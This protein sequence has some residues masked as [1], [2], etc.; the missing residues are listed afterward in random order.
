MVAVAARED[1]DGAF[2]WVGN[3]LN[4]GAVIDTAHGT[5]HGRHY[6]SRKRGSRVLG[7][8]VKRWR[9][10]GRCWEMDAR[11]MREEIDAR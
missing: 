4:G 3:A 1:V 11:K 8:C 10:G 6:D 9:L 7:R 5:S 2:A